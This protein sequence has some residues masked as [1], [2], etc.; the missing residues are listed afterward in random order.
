MTEQK[1]YNISEDRFWN[2]CLNLL[3]DDS[4]SEV[5]SNGPDQVFIKKSGRRIHLTQVVYPSDEA[6]AESIPLGLVPLITSHVEYDGHAYIFEGPIRYSAGGR[7]IRGRCHIVLPPAADHPQVTIAKKSTALATL[8]A[9]ASKGSMAAEM[10]AFVKASVAADMTTVLSGGT[11]AGKTTFLEALCKHIPLDTRIGV[12][13]DTPELALPHPNATYLHS[14]PW[15]PGMDEK[16]VASL[17]WVVA[18]FNR[19]RTDKLIIGETRG[20]EFSDFLVAANSGMEGSLTTL[21]ANE[22]KRALDKMTNFALKGA[23][24]TPIRSINVDIATSVDLV[25][26]LAYFK[27]D[28]RYRMTAVEEITSTIGNTDSA[29]ITTNRLYTYDAANDNWEKVSQPTDDLRKKFALHNVDISEIMKSAPGTILYSPGG[30]PS[31]GR[32]AAG[33]PVR[34]A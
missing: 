10:L 4:I 20:K 17:S 27:S 33:L 24:G 12:A 18:Q 26:Q 21:H 14:V 11:G 19:M 15:R 29:N 28:S 2:F 23:P 6:Y 1:L 32:S 8:D 13:E 34:R 5:E 16:D 31:G 9:I 30:D 25:F 22:P 3:L 7:D